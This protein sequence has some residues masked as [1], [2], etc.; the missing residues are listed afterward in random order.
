MLL[1]SSVVLF[2]IEPGPIGILSNGYIGI[3]C[4]LVSL[5]FVNAINKSPGLAFYGLIVSTII[6]VLATGEYYVLTALMISKAIAMAWEGSTKEKK[7][8]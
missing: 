3:I 7:E 1:S 8:L 5:V 6:G 2:D 4:C